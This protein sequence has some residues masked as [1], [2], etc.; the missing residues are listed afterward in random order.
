MWRRL[1]GINLWT[2][3]PWTTEERKLYRKGNANSKCKWE[4]ESLFIYGEWNDIV[5]S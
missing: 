4:M 1:S 2:T 5:C 3:G